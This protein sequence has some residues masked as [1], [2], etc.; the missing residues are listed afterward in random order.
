MKVGHF[1]GKC[2]DIQDQLIGKTAGCGVS[3][4]LYVFPCYSLAQQ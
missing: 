4:Y 2:F 3:P 1:P